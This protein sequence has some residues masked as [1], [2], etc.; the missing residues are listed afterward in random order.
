MACASEVQL[1][2]DAEPA[3]CWMEAWSG[4]WIFLVPWGGGRAWLLSSGGPVS[5]ALSASRL[6][7]QRIAAV[8]REGPSFPSAPGVLDPLR[9][10]DWLA[11]GS[12]AMN[13]DPICGD[14]VAYAVREGVLAS[15]V[16]REISQGRDPEKLLLH[17][18]N[19]M[20]AG[21]QRHLAM[22]L[23]YYQGAWRTPWWRREAAALQEGVAWCE[24][25]VAGPFQYRL[26]GFQLEPV[27]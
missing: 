22:C 12:A 18:Q 13:F 23:E 4:G 25:R 21:F 5:E 2:R 19:R 27:S 10:P 11:C 20:L 3:T 8:E 7:A 16:A 1:R 6:V 15:A 26:R 14:G 17:Y 9:G 24:R